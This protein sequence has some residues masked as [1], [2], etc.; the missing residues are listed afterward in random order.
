MDWEASLA[1]F[2]GKYGNEMDLGWLTEQLQSDMIKAY[3][4]NAEDFVIT[5]Q[6]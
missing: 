6:E 3:E 2:K 4:N 5:F 1:Y